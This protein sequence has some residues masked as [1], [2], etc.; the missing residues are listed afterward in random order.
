MTPPRDGV[1][2]AAAVRAALRRLVAARGFHGT[3][4]GAVAKEAGVATGTAYVH[5]PSKDELV[6]AAY[7]EAKREL[8]D[9]AAARVD[10]AAPARARFEQLWLGV[11]DHLCA[12]PGRARFLLQV[13]VSP[14]GTEAHERA[15]AV[16]DDPLVALAAEPDLAGRLVDLPP[17]VLYD[18]A[19]G[20]IVR[21]AA[22]GHEPERA[23]LPTLIESCW[24]AITR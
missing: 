20:P 22:A 10:A 19:V 4:M 15:L 3:S 23:A 17:L 12:D 6:H 21:I 9:A 7:L 11:Y 8:G 24:R 2:R 16:A 18:L 5:Y 13:E 14:Y 1:D